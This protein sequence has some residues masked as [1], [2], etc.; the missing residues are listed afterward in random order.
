MFNA[1]KKTKIITQNYSIQK[2][3]INEQ[4]TYKPKTKETQQVYE[5]LLTIVKNKLED[6][7]HSTIKGA[8]DEVLAVLK[9]DNKRDSVRKSEVEV[10]LGKISNEEFN[11]LFQLS[12][13]LIDY[14]V[15]VDDQ[16]G[17]N[18]E[19]GVNL[20]IEDEEKE[21]D[22]ETDKE[23]SGEEGECSDEFEK[24]N[25]NEDDDDIPNDEDGEFE[26]EFKPKKPSKSILKIEEIGGLWLEKE[27]K[28]NFD[29][30][31]IVIKLEKEILKILPVGDKRECENKLVLLLT[32]EKF[33]FIKV[34]L[35]NKWE[36]YFCVK[37]GKA[38]SQEEIL[39]IVEEMEN[40]PEGQEIKAKLL[41]SKEIKKNKNLNFSDIVNKKNTS[42]SQLSSDLSKKQQKRI[43]NLESLQFESRYV[44]TN[45]SC[46]LPK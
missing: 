29:D 2:L 30:F 5:D 17:M 4:L 37:L 12:K 10:F 46:Q 33:P 45:I 18:A 14:T 26:E 8:L 22:D 13:N 38:Q 27:I 19:V 42:S 34:L 36:I 31:N 1:K 7:S 11:K 24:P 28:K 20:Q 6:E 9:T 32:Q 16:D 43:L 35:E 41:S 25:D 23:K 3:D 15:E 39:E 40:S 21:S 44:M